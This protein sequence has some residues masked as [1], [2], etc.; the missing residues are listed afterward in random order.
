MQN[1][2]RG[3]EEM[4]KLLSM[5][6][7]LVM[8]LTSVFGMTACGNG[9]GGDSTTGNEVIEM[10]ISHIASESDP[11]HMGWSFLK[12]QL[13]ERSDGRIKVTIY[14]NKALSNSNNEDAEKVQQII[15]QMTSVPTSSLAAIGNIQE[16]QVFDYPYLFETNEDFYTVLDS[17][18]A[19]GWSDRLTSAAGVKALGGYS[20][21]WLSVGSV[22]KLG[23]LKD[24]KGQ[25]I[26]TLSSDLQMQ[27]VNA[28][29]A[30]ATQIN[31][32]ECYTALQQGTVDGI[33][34]STGLFVSDKFMEVIDE[35]AVAKPTALLHVPIVNAEW[36][37]ALPEDLKVIYDEC[38]VDY[39]AA[40]R[41]YEADFDAEALKTIAD[42]GVKVIEYTDAEL[43]EFKAAT[44]SVYEKYAD[45]AGQET[46]DAVRTIL[47]K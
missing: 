36:Y 9:D 14:S 29:G 7:V 32:G 10:K 5:F 35:L 30:S 40:V 13:E 26:R 3:E 25:K 28:Y 15:V 37:E 39:L 38:I 24:Y 20:L 22:K 41:Q 46:I 34:T 8:V 23:T 6:L 2:I 27:T 19:K 16:Y 1:Q 43:G 42:S 45:I 47:G 17:E 31:Y 12:E 18:L 21:G 11:I 33:L 44:E 4:K